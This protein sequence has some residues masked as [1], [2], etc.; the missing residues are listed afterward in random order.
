MKKVI[1]IL[2][3]LLI[4]T[5]CDNSNPTSSSDENTSWVFVANEGS[6][7]ASTG[8]ISMINDFGEVFETEAIGDVVQSLAVYEN[9]LIVLINNSHKIKIYDITEDG[10]TMPG[11]EVS[12]DGSSP[13]E[14]IV[15]DGN[16]YFTNW[17]TSDVKILN[18]T[19]Y[20]LDA[21]IPVGAM[22][23]G[24]LT[25]GSK[26]WVANSGLSLIHI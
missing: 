6:F 3:P 26:I 25:D 9:K 5:A 13:R 22:P 14:M 7:G 10:L 23:E 12:T 11:I 4:I 17:N 1:L 18:L 16:V 2:L 19:N 15:V 8:S 24:I 21:S 20:T